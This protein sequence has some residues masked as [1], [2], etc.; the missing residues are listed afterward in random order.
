MGRPL[1]KRFFA[2]GVG[3]TI[4]CN[5]HDGS[6][7]I[8]SAIISQKSS[9]QFRIA[10]VGGTPLTFTDL[11]FA[12][13]N[14]DTIT[15]TGGVS[16]ITSGFVVGGFVR[17]ASSENT[18]ENDGVYEIAG[19]TA[20]IITITLD[21]DFVVNTDDVAA[22]LAI[23][24]PNGVLARLVSG[25]PSAI[26]EMQITV[27]PEN[28]VTPVTAQIAFTSTS[29]TGSLLTV[30]LDNPSVAYG[31]WA[32]GTA[33]DIG[34][35]TDGTVDYTVDG[36]GR[37]ATVTIN[38]AGSTNTQSGSPVAL[39]DTAAANPPVQSVSKLQARTVQTFEGNRYDWPVTSP[40]GDAQVA[41]SRTQCNLQS[42][43]L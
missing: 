43:D 38:S 23:V 15:R 1:N 7:V 5:T 24:A 11:A 10:G 6:N 41:G 28:A 34:G 2:N 12:E 9:T 18:G 30:T 31:Y 20:T 14:P 39:A 22:T 26:G 35:T 33:V 3:A 37:I 42:T 4:G 21:G 29:G 8:E 16:F 19:V 17:V 13:A 32:A 36:S 40:L 25:A 27:T